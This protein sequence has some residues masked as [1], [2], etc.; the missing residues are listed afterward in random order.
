MSTILL[1]IV[2]EYIPLYSSV[3]ISSISCTII[4]CGKRRDMRLV[5]YGRKNKGSVGGY[6]FLLRLFRVT[7]VFRGVV[8]PSAPLHGNESVVGHTDHRCKQ[9]GKLRL[10]AV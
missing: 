6:S 4:W 9:E 5:V 8:W 2:P 1:S 10:R 7:Q 3:L